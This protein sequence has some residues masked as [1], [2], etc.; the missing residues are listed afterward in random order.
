MPIKIS[1][2]VRKSLT[3]ESSVKMETRGTIRLTLIVSNNA[4]IRKNGTRN[5]VFLLF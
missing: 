1:L 4:D 2:E 3:D 5:R